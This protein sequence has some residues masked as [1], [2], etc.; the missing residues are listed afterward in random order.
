MRTFLS[1]ALLLTAATA[2]AD[3]FGD[4]SFT[5]KRNVAAPSEGVTRI[6]IVGRAGWLHI[7]G[8]RGV[9]EVRATGSACASTRELLT[10]TKLTLSRSGSELRIEAETPMD[11]GVFGSAKLDFEVSVPDSMALR[12]EDGSGDMTIENVGSAEVTDG[13]GDMTIRGVNGDLVIRDGSGDMKIANVT[14]NIRINDGSGDIGVDGAGS[15]EIANDGSGSV[16]VHHVKHDVHIGNKGSGSV[17]VSD[18]GGDFRVGNK[19]GGSVTWDRVAG[20][21]DVPER[22]RR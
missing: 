14:G 22:F 7:A 16:D 12:V 4:C 17:E 11:A 5:E 8:R 21:V 15:V 1:L 3:I 6:V 9:G 18:V 10:D 13:S 2:S 19:G 20:H